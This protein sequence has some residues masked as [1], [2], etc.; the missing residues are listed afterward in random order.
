KQDT[1]DSDNLKNA[2]AISLGTLPKLNISDLKSGK[3]QYD[4]LKQLEKYG[5]TLLLIG[6]RKACQDEVGNALLLYLKG[7]DLYEHIVI[8]TQTWLKNAQF[9]CKKRYEYVEHDPSVAN[10]SIS[11]NCVEKESEEF[12]N[13]SKLFLQ[14]LYLFSKISP[15]N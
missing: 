1:N 3:Q 9:K 6:D 8:K 14:C 7:L 2:L 13:C 15:K 10:H 12:K 4:E 5:N 11:P